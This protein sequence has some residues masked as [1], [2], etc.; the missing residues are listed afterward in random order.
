MKLLT[1]AT[2]C[3]FS[4]LAA[5]QTGVPQRSQFTLELSTDGASWTR[6][7]TLDTTLNR[8][9]FCRVLIDYYANGGITPDWL[10]VARSQPLVTGWRAALGDT[11]LPMNMN[12]RIVPDY[13]LTDGDGY[14]LGR[15]Y[16]QTTTPT[17]GIFQYSLDG[18][19][20]LRIAE[21]LA[22][23]HPGRG[24][25]SNNM[26]GEAGLNTSG[27]PLNAQPGLSDIELFV[28]GMSF[29]PDRTGSLSIS[30]PR[31]AFRTSSA[32]ANPPL[33]RSTGWLVR[34]STF[35]FIE[36]PMLDTLG[37]EITFVPAPGALAP[38]GAVFAL[39]FRRRR[40]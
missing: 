35:A 16:G 21:Y 2:L 17:T 20:Y 31:E 36:A 1:T 3:L 28:W 23:Q 15:T 25:G 14:T 40:A 19:N 4:T 6:N 5:A 37:A 30:I 32:G 8:P 12:H 24:M 10:N 33:T 39:T 27:N 29:A 26:N 7:L 18:Q 11:V 13:S 22:T 34:D 38:F 9:V